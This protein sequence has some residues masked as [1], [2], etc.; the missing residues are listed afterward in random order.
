[1]HPYTVDVLDAGVG[2]HAFGQVIDCRKTKSIGAQQHHIREF[3]RRDTADLGIDA[4][5]LGATQCCDVHVIASRHRQGNLF[6]K[7]ALGIHRDISSTNVL[8]IVEH[9]VDQMIDPE[10][11]RY[12]E[13]VATP[14]W[15]W[16]IH[17]HFGA[18]RRGESGTSVLDHK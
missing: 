4:Q 14:Q 16:N 8:K 10:G 5:C 3:A 11:N 6:V 9:V 18:R 7:S 15:Q 12:A 2:I 1:M 17:S 13:L